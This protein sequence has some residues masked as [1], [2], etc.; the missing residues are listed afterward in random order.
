MATDTKATEKVCPVCK[1]E[2][3]EEDNYCGIDGERLVISSFN[4]VPPNT[5]ADREAVVE[6]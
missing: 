4:P 2:Y 3:P 5:P 6:S 1:R